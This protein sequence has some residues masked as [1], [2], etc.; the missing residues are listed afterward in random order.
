MGYRFRK[1][2]LAAAIN[3]L[4]MAVPNLA[5]AV[6]VVGGD[7]GWEVSVD[8]AV[9]GYYV[10]QDTDT[11]PAAAAPA[12]ALYG[13]TI[14]DDRDSSRVTS[15]LE[16]A[17]IGFSVQSPTVNGLTG[18]AHITVA[19][20]IHNAKTKNTT[21]TFNTAL[22]G[23][24]LD[25][26][27]AFF[28]VYG[29]FGTISVGR[30]LSMFQRQN[31]LT[32]MSLLGVGVAGDVD[33][34]AITL[35]HSGYGYLY[36]NYNARIAYRTPNVQGIALEVGVFDPSNISHESALFPGAPFVGGLGVTAQ[37]TDTPR[38][39]GEISYATNFGAGIFQAWA[40]GLWQEAEFIGTN[41]DVTAW[42]AAG[43]VMVGYLGF[44]AVASG[45]TGEALG[46]TL[47][48]DQ[49]ALD[50]TG[51]ERD[52]YG[53]Y[54]QGA[55][56]FAGLT[57]VG[58]SYGTSMADETTFEQGCR[59]SNPIV[60]LDPRCT[61]GD[62]RLEEQH[63]WTVGVYHDATSWLKLAAEYSN[64]ENEWFG[65]EDQEADLFAVGGYFSW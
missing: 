3:V 55:Y 61:A 59:V 16:P 64:V 44:E 17:F 58:L 36:P 25:V 43:G 38:F 19:P 11:R 2:P 10:N 5:G 24:S 9:S 53:W 31:Y 63:A 56:T 37:E 52:H 57:K 33:R 20:V 12:G 26:R 47:M 23:S 51:E 22:T 54:A 48:L 14:S 41:T 50:A 42:G 35:G 60:L 49:D 65:G 4:V 34:G 32:D 6:V 29:T 15:G 30:T 46:T 21:N 18:R 40:S 13:G 8:G 28:D 62:T 45:Y 7:A 39:E 27:E 1:R